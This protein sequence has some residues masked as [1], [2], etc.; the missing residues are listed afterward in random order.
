MLECHETKVFVW[1]L[2]DADGF[3]PAYMDLRIKQNGTSAPDRV[4]FIDKVKGERSE[5]SSC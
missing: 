4:I 2:F 1:P 5:D 3:L